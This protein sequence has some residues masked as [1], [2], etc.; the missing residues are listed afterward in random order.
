M[1]LI[2]TSILSAISQMIK[3]ICGFIITKVIAI[4]GGPS[5][6]A[7]IGQ[8]Q[9]FIS[10]VLMIAGDFMKTATT[11]Y[12]AEYVNEDERKFQ[13]WSLSIKFI[14]ISNIIL[15]LILFF[16]SGE[17]SNYLLKSTEYSYVLKIF[18]FTLPFFVL[19][20]MLLSIL[21]GHKQIKKYIFINILLS[22]IS[23]ILVVLLSVNFGI[24][25]ALIAYVTNQS[26][27][28][29]ITVVFLKTESW[30]KIKNFF[31]DTDKS[32]IKK[33]FGFAMITLT[34][35]LA[36]NFS[37]ITIRDYITVNISLNSAGYWQS[38]WTL[39]QVSLGLITTS[40]ATYFLPTLSALREKNDISKEL[41]NT[42]KIILPIAFIISF[43]MYVL[44]DFI[45]LVLY[46]E[47]FNPMKELFLWQMIGNTIKV[48]GWLF[49]YVLVAKAMVKYTV[50]TEIIFAIIF[51]SL[52]IY[53]INI[54]GLV[55]VTYAYATNSLVHFFT[56]YYIYKYK[57]N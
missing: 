34:A 14:L 11:K 46:T 27:I 1:T 37:L 54:Y 40:L 16:F 49:G 4:Y 29:V 51:I 36:S 23:L 55:G 10:I 56:M 17:I 26:V 47:E 39:S 25:G 45:I 53:F 22:L 31:F 52:S 43:I 18:A 35:V 48:A 57:I 15:F 42:I 19:N 32:D 12:T 41:K 21:N 50:S 38:I 6:M 3:I 7:I 2:K 30:F 13:F 20:T 8:L 9:N 5:G 33:L 24:N 28:F 44:K